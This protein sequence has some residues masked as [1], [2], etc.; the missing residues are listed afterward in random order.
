[1]VDVK[2]ALRMPASIVESGPAAGVIAAILA[3]N[4]SARRRCCPSTWRHHRE[5]VPDQGR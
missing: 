5:G 2:E 1:V 4:Q 3:G